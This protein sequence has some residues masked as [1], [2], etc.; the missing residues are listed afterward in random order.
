MQS[1]HANSDVGQVKILKLYRGIIIIK[2]LPVEVV[3]HENPL[4]FLESPIKY[5][6]TFQNQQLKR[7]AVTGSINDILSFLNDNGY[8]VSEYGAKEA[9]NSMIIAFRDDG[10]IQIDKSV[11]FEGY[12][13]H[14][15]DIHASKIDINK[16]H[17]LRTKDECVECIKFIEMLSG[18]Y[19]WIYKGME[20]DRRR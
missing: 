12:Y 4:T 2:C 15:G 9:L 13:Y 8:T 10:H 14:N 7:F 18:F 11:D 16:K 17:P 20:I 6:I 5:T 19:L 3:I 1:D